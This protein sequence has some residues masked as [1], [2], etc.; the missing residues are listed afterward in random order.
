MEY[1]YLL[2]EKAN[3]NLDFEDIANKNNVCALHILCYHIE[4]QCTYPFLQ[5]M[6]DKTLYSNNILKEQLILPYIIIRNEISDLTELVLTRVKSSLDILGCDYNR[7]TEDMYKGII[8]GCDCETLYALV[9]ITGI[10]ISGLNIMTQ[11]SCWFV[12]P[13][14]IINTK[15]VCNVDIDSNVTQLFTDNPGLGLLMN[16]K[17][18]KYFMIPDAVYTGSEMKHSE[19][20]SVFGNI[21][22]KIYK[23]CGEYYFF[24]RSFYDAVKDGGW[25]KKG[26]K[27]NIGHR[28]IVENNSNKYVDGFINRY[29]LF[30]EGKIYL[31]TEIEFDLDDEKIETEYPEQCIII[32]YT[33]KHSINPDIL[34][35][36]YESFVSLSYHRLNKNLLGQNFIE[37]NKNTY[38]IA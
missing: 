38:M 35:K 6:M 29:A 24:Y 8:F 10:N 13:S 25:L 27:D 14:E 12:L 22:K 5:F 23:N 16:N 18:N 33:D 36:S 1:K 37:E 30:V 21:K 15:K 4:D 20:Q 19:F 34:V 31:E 9:N 11:T 26:D 7:V 2:E 32:C 3:K 28:I 17:T